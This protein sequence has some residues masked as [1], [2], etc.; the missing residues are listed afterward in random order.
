MKEEKG[1][2]ERKIWKRKRI[3]KK[4]KKYEEKTR[5]L[6]NKEKNTKTES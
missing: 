4:E 1:K 2:E 5:V 3:R 6:R